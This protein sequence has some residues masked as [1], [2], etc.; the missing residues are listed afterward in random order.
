MAT[1]PRTFERMDRSTIRNEPRRKD[2]MS[3]T[4]S[5]PTT[6][7]KSAAPF[8]A[9]AILAGV[10]ALGAIG[11]VYGQSIKATPVAG[12]PVDV[13]AALIEHR[14]AERASLG[15]ARDPRLVV[16][17]AE[18]LDRGIVIADPRL[19]V[20]QAEL[21]DRMAA[22][23]MPANPGVIMAQNLVTPTYSGK[24][25][26]DLSG[27]A[28]KPY[29]PFAPTSETPTNIGKALDDLSMVDR[30]SNLALI[31]SEALLADRYGVGSDSAWFLGT[32]KAAADR[33]G[34]PGITGTGTGPQT[35]AQKG[36]TGP[37]RWSI[38]AADKYA[39][40]QLSRTVVQ[41]KPVR[42]HPARH[43]VVR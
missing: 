14:A 5:Q 43:P 8:G 24:V 10:V 31:Q 29:L 11:I 34:R 16:N 27:A 41:P 18:L 28:S 30:A 1:S 42:A 7:H 17:S 33:F 13:Q 22:Q 9:V 32:Q 15:T 3:A 2:A 36:L 26:D 37:D 20:N 35:G 6:G 25:R 38:M 21:A 40:Q 19:L 12:T 4:I 39:Q 23:A